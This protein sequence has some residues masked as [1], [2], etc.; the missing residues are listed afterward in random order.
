[1]EIMNT[2]NSIKTGHRLLLLLALPLIVIF[3]ILQPANSCRLLIDQPLPKDLRPKNQ[4]LPA[5][6]QQKLPPATSGSDAVAAPAGGKYRTAPPPP[7]EGEP[8][9]SVCG[10]WS[11]PGRHG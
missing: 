10:S 11:P 6:I 3:I 1:M 8:S 5:N 4:T 7:L 9:I 2:T